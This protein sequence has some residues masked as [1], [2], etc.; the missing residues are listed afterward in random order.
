MILKELYWGL[1]QFGKK[2]EVKQQ[3]AI[4][5]Q[6]PHFFADNIRLINYYYLI[7]D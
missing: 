1:Q 2:G 4:S 3:N 7:I 6:N 5:S